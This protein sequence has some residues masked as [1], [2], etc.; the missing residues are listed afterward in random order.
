M[1][2]ARYFFGLEYQSHA[3]LH[4]LA[5]KRLRRCHINVHVLL[6]RGQTYLEAQS[7]VVDHFKMTAH[8]HAA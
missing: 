7:L 4:L 8:E 6:S 5:N 3:L 1:I 2:P